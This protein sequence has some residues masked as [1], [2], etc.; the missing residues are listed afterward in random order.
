ML[1]MHINHTGYRIYNQS[2][3]MNLYKFVQS[4]NLY[5]IYISP[6]IEVSYTFHYFKIMHQGAFMNKK[7]AWGEILKK[8]LYDIYFFH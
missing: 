3:N 8:L 6:N 7:L 1:V 5:F 2:T 4:T